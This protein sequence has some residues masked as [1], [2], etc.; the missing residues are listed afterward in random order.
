MVYYINDIVYIQFILKL[1]VIVYTYTFQNPY[2]EIRHRVWVVSWLLITGHSD[3]YQEHTA[4][5]WKCYAPHYSDSIPFIPL[6]DCITNQD[7][8][9]L[10]SDFQ[11]DKPQC[12]H[13]ERWWRLRLNIFL[14]VISYFR[15]H[16]H[17]NRCM[18]S[19][20]A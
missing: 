2:C 9:M 13:I 7:A 1:F 5:H 14:Y 11:R 16:M 17:H 15:A 12:L 8:R 6:I 3:V 4:L 10:S 18:G 20:L 19:I